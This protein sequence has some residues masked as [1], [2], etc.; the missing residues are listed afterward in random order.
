M[1]ESGGEVRPRAAQ[2]RGGTPSG[3]VFDIKKAAIHDGPGLRTT[4][5]L[6]G[7]PLRCVWCH[8]PE[9]IRFEPQL[10]FIEIK[11]TRC[12][13]CV[14]ACERGCHV[15]QDAVHRFDRSRCIRCGRCV[16]ACW[17]GALEFAG[18]EMTVAEVMTTV[19][20]DRAYFDNSGGGL[21]LSGGEPL[22]QPEFTRALLESAKSERL[23]TCL[24]TCGYAPFEHFEAVRPLVDRFLYD[25]KETDPELHVRFTGRDNT[26]ILDNLRRLDAGGASLELRCPIVPGYNDRD[27][28]FAAIGALA[29]SLRHVVG[30]TVM[31]FHPYGEHKCRQLGASYALGRLAAPD[32]DTVR[33]WRANIARHTRLPVN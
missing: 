23:H 5:F 29:E 16:E 2:N 14:S 25:I 17:N 11:C 3:V 18:R 9:S 19:L 21:T 26:L 27:D 32:K 10:K 22:A 24:D 12:G 1:N 7:C 6:K 30:I 4:V 28:H 13:R 8:N 20:K 31:P 15:L 33:T